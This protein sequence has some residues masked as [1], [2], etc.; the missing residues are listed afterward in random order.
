VTGRSRPSITT[1]SLPSPCILMK[2]TPFMMRVIGRPLAPS[3]WLSPA[4]S[5]LRS[6]FDAD[7]WFPKSGPEPS[8]GCPLAVC[9]KPFAV[10]PKRSR[11]N[12]A[13]GPHHEGPLGSEGRHG[14]ACS[15][16]GKVV[17][18]E[19]PVD[20][21]GRVSVECGGKVIGAGFSRVLV[22]RQVGTSRGIS[23]DHLEQKSLYVV[24][25]K[26]YSRGAR[27]AI[28]A[29]QCSGGWGYGMVNALSVVTRRC[30]GHVCGGPLA[31]ALGDGDMPVP[32]DRVCEPANR[33]DPGTRGMAAS[34][35]RAAKL[36][37]ANW[38]RLSV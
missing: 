36:N 1:K 4:W 28:A 19:R 13:F 26:G 32:G 9:L 3:P 16:A 15:V 11:G 33:L 8:A 10:C 38:N 21:S 25:T 17:M 22:I 12:E 14:L 29:L 23:F 37:T 35:A 27:I 30:R 34:A 31:S 7:V 20:M 6:W 18:V 5:R 24:V 2:G